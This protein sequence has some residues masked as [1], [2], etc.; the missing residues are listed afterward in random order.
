M[1]Q[2]RDPHSLLMKGKYTSKTTALAPLG[3][4]TEA[5]KECVRA[6]EE[7]GGAGELRGEGGAVEGSPSRAPAPEFG[8]VKILESQL[9]TPFPMYNHHSADIL[10]ICT[11]WMRC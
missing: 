11:S 3:S 9:D 10:G 1:E 6:P 7:S 4:K 5:E 8:Q 2:S